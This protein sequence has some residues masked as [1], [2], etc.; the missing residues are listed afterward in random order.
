MEFDNLNADINEIPKQFRGA[1]FRLKKFYSVPLK[2]RLMKKVD[3][4]SPDECWN[5]KGEIANT[6]YGIFS[7]H[8]KRFLAHR[9]AWGAM[10]G[11]I[12]EGLFICH[13]CD[14]PACC[15]PSHLFLGTPKD[16][17]TDMINKRRKKQAKGE[18]IGS[19]ILN[20]HQVNEIRKRHVPFH[21][22]QS[23]LA[24]EY[25]V[26]K[27]CIA[28]ITSRRKWKHINLRYKKDDSCV[29]VNNLPQ[30]MVRC[31]DPQQP[32]G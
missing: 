21:V 16:N 5:F 29:G 18:E 1:F 19:C 25:G 12:P 23:F 26:S 13:H 11:E 8:K 32:E 28:H 24:K 22:S 7:I 30:I 3:V 10:N 6:G 15:N 14:N 17:V 20:E 9:I 27:S 2:D 31:C 4:K